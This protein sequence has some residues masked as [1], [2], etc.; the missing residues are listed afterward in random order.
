M[1]KFYP[2][3]G[4]VASFASHCDTGSGP[5]DWANVPTE[6]LLLNLDRFSE[7]AGK[8]PAAVLMILPG[9][10]NPPFAFPVAQC[11]ALKDRGVVPH[12][13]LWPHSSIDWIDPRYRLEAILRGEMDDVMLR[14]VEES[15]AYNGPLA[16][17]PDWEV[18][19]LG[20][21]L[22]PRDGWTWAADAE[23]IQLAAEQQRVPL[24]GWVETAEGPQP[25]GPWTYVQA[26]RHIMDIW[27]SV[28]P[29]ITWHFHTCG[30]WYSLPWTHPKWWYAGGFDWVG[31][32]AANFSRTN[33][34]TFR[35]FASKVAREISEIPSTEGLPFFV[36]VGSPEVIGDEG[37]KEQ[38]Y[39]EVFDVLA[40]NE[41]PR[42]M[43]NGL[44]LEQWNDRNER[45]EYG[46]LTGSHIASSMRGLAAARRVFSDNAVSAHVRQQ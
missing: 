41:I 46:N 29:G 9:Y 21:A 5:P 26:M 18:P 19:N 36:E 22:I 38:Y 3:T 31:G 12:L 34:I 23:L 1:Q 13:Y 8:E 6:Q 37:F 7:E 32:S 39:H 25:V 4:K 40:N 30:D 17:A 2:V 14:S 28:R 35:D 20:G 15:L 11:Q 45:D 10:T 33:P 42:L 24:A 44:I 16:I 43:V 27:N